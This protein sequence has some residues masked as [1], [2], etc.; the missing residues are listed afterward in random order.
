MIIVKLKKDENIER[1]LKRFKTKFSNT[2]VIKELRERSEFEKP[3][4]KK[5]KQQ[6]KSEYIQ[7]LN[8]NND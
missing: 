2:K 7:K 4:E 5:R 3:S 8:R 1:A 6:K